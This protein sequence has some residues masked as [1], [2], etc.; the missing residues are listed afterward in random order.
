MNTALL[1]QN[2]ILPTGTAKMGSI[3]Y[4]IA[5][6]SSP[7]NLT[8]LNRIPVRYV[9]GAMVYLGDIAFLYASERA[10]NPIRRIPVFRIEN[11]AEDDLT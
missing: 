6:N 2:V 3:E 7:V 4:D 9:N 8:D 11:S 5:T 1:T 10:L